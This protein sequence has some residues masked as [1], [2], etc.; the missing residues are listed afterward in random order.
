MPNAI[1][2]VLDEEFNLGTCTDV[3]LY[4]V[5]YGLG[6]VLCETYS[7]PLGRNI[8]PQCRECGRLRPFTVTTDLVVKRATVRCRG[9]GHEEVVHT[10]PHR[11]IGLVRDTGKGWAVDVYWGLLPP[12]FS[13]AS[14]G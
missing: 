13:F 4:S 7:R 10:P 8:G 11:Y 6:F 5:D 1:R 9:C 14:S 12:S 3:Y 2:R